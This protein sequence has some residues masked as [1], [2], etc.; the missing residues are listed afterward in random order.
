MQMI[1]KNIKDKKGITLVTLSIAIIIM[2]IITSTLIF[3][4]STGTK[5]K[6]LN[7]MYH[8]IEKL[9]DKVDIYY[10]KYR[11]LPI[12]EERYENI[13]NIA[14]INPNDN[15]EYYVI[16]L[17]ALE[18]ITLAYGRDYEKYK[19]N[20]SASLT[21]LYVIN[22][23]S[24]TVYY[25]K[26]I[27]FDNQMYYTIPEEN[28]QVELNEIL[29]LKLI[30][31]YN[32]VASIKIHAVDKTN[33]VKNI[34]LI[35]NEQ[36]YKTYQYD[37]NYR[38]IREEVEQIKTEELSKWENICYFQVEDEQGAVKKSNQIVIEKVVP[39]IKQVQIGDY[40]TYDPTLGVTNT[41]KLTYTSPVGSGLSH[42]NGYTE[43]AEGQTFTAK[44]T[45]NGG[46]KWRVL[47]KDEQTGEV[48]L[49]SDT[50]IGTDAGANFTM[51]GAIGYLY[52]EQELNEICKIYGYGKGANTG[53]I[54]QYKTGDVV[55]GET[56]GTI[57]GSGARS[58]T[59][60]DINKIVGYDPSTYTTENAGKTYR[61]GETYEHNI[62]YP[63]KTTG[64]GAST[65]AMQRSDKFTAYTYQVSQ[66]LTDTTSPK[67]QMLLGNGNLRYWIAS[68]TV[69]SYS[70]RVDFSVFI[71]HMGTM[72][73][74]G[75]C[76]GYP[77]HLL[78][79]LPGFAIR[80]IVYLTPDI[81]TNGKEA[82]GAWVI[83]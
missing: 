21:D 37:T 29:E 40:V 20:P 50:P 51:Y 58:I 64:D 62:F 83:K 57:K 13:N 18:N 30:E 48:V 31:E 65:S 9:K 49:I 45:T 77:D 74:Y 12:V 14:S 6:N 59:V 8:D 5:V 36:P 4:I 52:A 15:N 28:T 81:Q 42:G 2:I 70:E 80:P 76:N 39:L 7:D 33:G 17:E 73:Y 69:A 43:L 78:K 56:T 63:T 34:T 44:S 26:G 16:D 10:S 61:Y 19:S 47:S 11:S 3:N 25:I 71:L 79:A 32:G 41:T 75:L 38:E 46:T 35:M 27:K 67:Y 68:E 66:Y 60:E 82:S 72:S 22:A 23:R 55:E 24:H 1:K 53:K 54:F